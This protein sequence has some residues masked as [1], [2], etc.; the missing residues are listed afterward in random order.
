MFENSQHSNI[1]SRKDRENYANIQQRLG[2][3]IYD[4]VT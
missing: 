4:I 3:I 2:L 1:C